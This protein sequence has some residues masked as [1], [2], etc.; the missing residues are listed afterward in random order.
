[1]RPKPVKLLFLGNMAT[2]GIKKEANGQKRVFGK[3]V[4]DAK[5]YF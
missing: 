1:M 3:F 2:L 4:R 5:T